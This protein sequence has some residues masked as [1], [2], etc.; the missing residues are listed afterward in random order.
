[1]IPEPKQGSGT[2]QPVPLALYF[3]V[4]VSAEGWG[5][6]MT[7]HWVPFLQTVHP[8]VGTSAAALTAGTI[9]F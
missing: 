9:Y 4:S 3:T 6:L 8:E 2:L 1:M 7:A 5:S